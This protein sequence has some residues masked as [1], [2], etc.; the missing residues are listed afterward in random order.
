MRRE[1]VPNHNRGDCAPCI[2]T[3]A[4]PLKQL[5]FYLSNLNP[6]NIMKNTENP[7]N[8]TATTADPA[9][10]PAAKS[11]KPHNL[12]NKRQL[13]EISY[14]N[15]IYNIVNGDPAILA[16]I[17]DTEVITPAFLT[18]LG[19]DLQFIGQYTG[20][21]TEATVEGELKTSEE[22][23]AKQALLA[24][25]HYIHSQA[26]IKYAANKGVLPEYAIGANIDASRPA[27]EAATATILNKLKT[28]TLPKIT[29]QHSTD[30][31]VSLNIYKK[32]KSD[33]QSK[34]GDST[35]LRHQLSAMVDTLAVRRRQLQH[36][37]DGE[38]PWTDPAN[39]GMRR[40]FDLPLDR[41]LNA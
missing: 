17:Q 38:Y 35:T 39:A 13:A 30:L 22:E 32:T 14:T 2:L 11:P 28:D 15:V 41:S 34:R 24:K 29:A 10:A 19:V 23:T 40:K 8:P 16:K 21:A 5:E 20:G 37:A 6:P 1:G 9:P 18:Q 33:Q 25:I 3:S 26:K 4:F 27:L 7:T 36:S 31:Q 12:L